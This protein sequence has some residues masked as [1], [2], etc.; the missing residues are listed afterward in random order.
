MIIYLQLQTVNNNEM[1]VLC[2]YK[3]LFNLM[4]MS[5]CD[6]AMEVYFILGFNVRTLVLV[7]VTS[8]STI[9]KCC[10]IQDTAQEKAIPRPIC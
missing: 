4:E 2:K 6:F 1:F 10:I 5:G 7:Q 8:I 9:T 3:Q